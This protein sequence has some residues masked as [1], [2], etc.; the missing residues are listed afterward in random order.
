MKFSIITPSF[1]NSAWLKL[2]LASVADQGIEHEHIVQDAG[3]D[4]GTLDWLR[5]DE[6]VRAFVEKDSGMYDAINRGLRKATGEYIAYLNCDEQYLPGALR[7]AAEFL[8]EHPE[9]E[10]LFGDAV[11]VNPAGD[12]LSHRKML[13]PR[14][15]HT[16]TCTLSVLTC[17]T[18]FRRSLVE[19]GF[20]F[21]ERWKI[22]GDSDWV[23]RLLQAGVRT[24]VL[25]RF[26]SVFTRTGSN[27]SQHE[28]AAGEMERFW[29]LA[30][31]HVRAL[32]P[33]ILLHHRLRR[34]LGGIYF[35]RPFDFELYTASNP[36]SRVV[37]HVEKPTFRWQW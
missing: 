2:C 22:V 5:H 11:C 10:I 30:P 16:W 26:T 7:A 1:R 36:Q 6:R 24:A 15:W 37:K 35:Q 4:D 33:G 14:L 8:D 19:R 13:A 21:D 3:S 9:V 34:L 17:A 31:R 28:S 18:F 20:F 27:L 29:S 25:W 23:L 12:Y 32:R